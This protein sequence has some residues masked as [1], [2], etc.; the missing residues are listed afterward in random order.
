MLILILQT[1]GGGGHSVYFWV[2][3]CCWDA[4]TLA[5]YQTMFN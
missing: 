4:E 2:G 3:V 1:W 5:L